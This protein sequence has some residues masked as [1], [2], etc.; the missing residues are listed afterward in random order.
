[1]N[2]HRVVVKLQVNDD[3]LRKPFEAGETIL[4]DNDFQWLKTNYPNSFVEIPMSEQEWLQYLSSEVHKSYEKAVK[5]KM[6]CEQFGLGV[7]LPVSFESR[8]G[9]IASA[10][11]NG[12][13]LDPD[14]Y[15]G[16]INDVIGKAWA[17]KNDVESYEKAVFAKFNVNSKTQHLNF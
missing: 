10:A 7:E 5:L 9:S 15:G 6:I 2:I 8:T 3:R 17:Y 11:I 4:S 13:M 14:A 16:G 1:M 12:K